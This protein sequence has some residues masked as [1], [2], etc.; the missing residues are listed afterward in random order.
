MPSCPKPRDN[1][2]P[3]LAWVPSSNL[4]YLGLHPSLGESWKIKALGDE[5]PRLVGAG[6]EGE[7][8]VPVH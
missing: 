7:A 6:R 2:N 5:N 4:A 3:Y 8:L 1:R